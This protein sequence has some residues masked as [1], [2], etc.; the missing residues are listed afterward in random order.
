MDTS[1]E[2]IKMCEQAVEIQKGS[3]F[4]KAEQ[5]DWFIPAV[6]LCKNGKPDK[7]KKRYYDFDYLLVAQ[8]EA[9]DIEASV[10]YS[11]QAEEYLI[12]LPRQ[13]QLQVMVGDKEW[14][15]EHDL[16]GSGA[17]DYPYSVHTKPDGVYHYGDS[18][19]E[20]LLK[21]VMSEKFN[22]TWN[23]EEWETQDA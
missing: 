9:E 17:N 12:W 7:K 20:A 3:D 16:T 11:L 4:T 10:D 13:D 19:E 22:K 2:Y 14:Y 15:L 21:Y 5:G 1:K 6:F 8:Y 23:S 18:P